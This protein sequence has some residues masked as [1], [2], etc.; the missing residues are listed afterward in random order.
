MQYPNP[1][2][3]S[4][5]RAALLLPALCLGAT[6][7]LAEIEDDT[8]PDL[9]PPAPSV[10][11]VIVKFRPGAAVLR[12]HALTP[13]A[14]AAEASATITARTHE[15][16]ARVAI[17]LR[18]GRAISEDTLAVVASGVTSAELAL[19]LAAQADIEYAVVDQRRTHF[20]VPND[21]Y[22]AQ[23]PALSG[24]SGGPA[25]GQW[26]LRA[27]AGDVVSGINASGAW[28][29]TTGSPTIVVAVLDT[30][31]RPDHPD[32]AGR[33]LPG[34]DMVSQAAEGNDGNARDA[35]AADPGD[36]V[37]DAES[38]ARAGP[39]EQ[40]RV[41]DSSWH[42]TKTASLVGAAANDGI[43][44]A[45]VAWGVWL[46]PV[47]VLGKCGGLDSDI[48]AGMRWAAGLSV[49]GLPVN[50]NPARVIN[51]S[52]GAIGGCQPSYR[53]T[54]NAIA[55]RPNPPGDRRGGGQQRRPGSQFA[56][57]LRRRARGGRAAPRGDQGR[58]FRHR[59]G[60]RDQ[61]AGRQ[62]RQHRNR[63]ALHVPDP[64]GDEYRAHHAGGVRVQRQ[65]QSERG[66]ELFVAAGG[67]HRRADALGQP[68]ADAR[69]SQGCAAGLRP[70]VS[71][72]QREHCPLLP[73]ARRHGPAGMLL[74]DVDLRS[75][76]A[77]CRGGGGGR[78][79]GRQRDRVSQR[80]TG[81]LLRHRQRRRGG[82][83]RWRQ[84]GSR[85]GA[86]RQHFQVR[87]RH[88]VLPLLRQPHP[89]PN[90]HFYTVDPLECAGLKEVQAATP[91]T[92]KRWNFESLDFMSSAPVGGACAN[93]AAPVYRAYNNGFARGIDSNH[94]LTR[95]A[96]AIQEVVNR[97]WI[98]EGVVMCAPD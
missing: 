30:G 45:G 95:N 3:H 11:R 38:A 23:G 67:R 21:P 53:D 2:I 76:H 62:L 52:L 40:C 72:A 4:L 18:P 82:G 27:P 49:P 41:Q 22:Y 56:G 97:G 1:R 85:L 51:M 80:G 19:R 89:G 33:L 83:D 13:A 88:A 35:D 74:H 69:A 5:I 48:L 50:F 73:G 71:A 75:R 31:V 7:A 54:I 47:R 17:D 32:L 81:Q 96:A 55:A 84:R 25:V 70:A 66:H 16:G 68:V 93:G 34:Y 20:A 9:R 12:K 24:A 8:A 79:A 64:R 37:T 91:I 63:R 10:A 58:L 94:R 46:V 26:Y 65:F 60:D 42:G 77:R 90:S 14:T 44:M 39:F 6:L 29:L 87:R 59:A 57:Q 98:A 86:H 36:W 92:Q 43:G 15:L 61:R 28:D 78:D